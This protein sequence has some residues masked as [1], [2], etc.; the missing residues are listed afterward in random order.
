MVSVVSRNQVPVAT[1]SQWC[2]HKSHGGECVFCPRIER[3]DQQTITVPVLLTWVYTYTKLHNL[4]CRR[5]LGATVVKA[6]HPF[7]SCIVRWP[8][9]D[10][11]ET[12]E[13]ATVIVETSLKVSTQTNNILL[14]LLYCRSL[15]I[16]RVILVFVFHC[17]PNDKVCWQFV[18]LFEK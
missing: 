16:K 4:E 9:N 10:T 13:N 15:N 3:E 18:T 17:L 8:H 14:E 6:I 12:D 7:Y 5:S 1:P 2:S 11:R